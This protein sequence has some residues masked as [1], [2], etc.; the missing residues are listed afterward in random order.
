MAGDNPETHHYETILF[1][2]LLILAVVGSTR[3]TV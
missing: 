1:A 3:A 2:I